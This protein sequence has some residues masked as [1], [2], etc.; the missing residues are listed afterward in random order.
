[1]S[2]IQVRD[3]PEEVHSALTDQARAAGLS[4]NRFLLREFERVA[5]RGHNA[6]VLRTTDTVRGRRP[7][8]AQIV[9]AVREDRRRGS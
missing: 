1:M 8:S 3:V 2:V 6:G 9:T 7:T 4:L 5:R